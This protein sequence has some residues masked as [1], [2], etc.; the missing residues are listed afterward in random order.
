M[1]LHLYWREKL[2]RIVVMD[3]GVVAARAK[4]RVREPVRSVMCHPTLWQW[5]CMKINHG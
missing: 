4:A 3:G 5:C 2:N 1:W